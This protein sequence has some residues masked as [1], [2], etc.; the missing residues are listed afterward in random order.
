[1]R[2][3]FIALLL[4]TFVASGLAQ[5]SA[6]DPGGWT[7]AKWGMTE[8]QIK[9][10]FPEAGPVRFFKQMNRLGLPTYNIDRIRFDV[11]FG[12]D[13]SGTLQ[14]VTLFD[15]FT[16]EGM[17]QST[18]TQ[19]LSAIPG[20]ATGIENVKRDLLSS[21]TAKYGKF[22]DH[23]LTDKGTQDEPRRS[24]KS[25]QWWSPEIRPMVVT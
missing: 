8:D 24:P 10:A 4:A 15:E 17:R 25:G 23:A 7:K 21:L 18:D 12:F 19:R 22:S 6:D 3:T 1:M 2:T 16:A 20:L 14:E 9:A 5:N 13:D 11:V